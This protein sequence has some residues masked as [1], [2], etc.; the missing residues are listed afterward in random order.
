[1]TRADIILRNANKI[2]GIDHKRLQME[3]PRAPTSE[4]SVP[5]GY[6]TSRS[7]RR[8]TASKRLFNDLDINVRPANTTSTPKVKRKVSHFMYSSKEPIY[9]FY[10]SQ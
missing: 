2:N 1:M 9:Q 10:G 8:L 4:N 3:K 5:L 6:R 7:G